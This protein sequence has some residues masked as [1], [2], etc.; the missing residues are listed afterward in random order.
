MI[1]LEKK[2]SRKHT[3]NVKQSLQENRK[4]R[5]AILVNQ[6]FFLMARGI[7][8]LHLICSSIN[9]IE[10]LSLVICLNAVL[11]SFNE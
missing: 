10:Y 2:Y 6:I 7:S 8:D 5:Q 4:Q 9:A 1:N 11:N 3:P